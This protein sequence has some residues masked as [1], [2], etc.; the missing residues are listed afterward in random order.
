LSEYE[1]IELFPRPGASHAIPGS[2]PIGR[3][4]DGLRVDDPKVSRRHAQV[5]VGAGRVTVADLGSRN[6]TYVN[7]E[8]IEGERELAIGDT[9]QV[10]PAAFRLA[11]AESASAAPSQPI[12][13]TRMRGEVPPPAP[14][15]PAAELGGVA[16][17][18]SVRPA[19]PDFAATEAKPRGSA[20]RSQVATAVCFAIVLADA[21][22]LAVYFA[23]R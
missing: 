21:I 2:L 8:R 10:G 18:A 9:I 5:D 4:V 12:D 3:R 22:A 15:T 14:A 7:D 1:L 20:A 19:A 17:A 6:G 23:I 16:A 13:A 11:R